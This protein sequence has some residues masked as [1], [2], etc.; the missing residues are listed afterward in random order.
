MH[1]V[2]GVLGAVSVAYFWY[3]RTRKATKIAGE[4]IEAA[5][6]V[7]LAARRFG[8]RRK[9]NVHPVD[10]I[11]DPRIAIS[12]IG[13]GFLELDGFPT[14]E[15]HEALIRGVR[16]AFRINHSSAEEM[17]VLGRWIV[18]Q[19]NGPDQSVPRLTKHLFK[20]DGHTHFEVMLGILKQIAAAGDGDRPGRAPRP[21]PRQRPAGRQQRR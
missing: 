7:R 14:A 2:L 9:A 4:L 18:T 20:L 3:L 15:K 11:D 5:N 6:D 12:A 16:E 21:H 1:I 17:I 8:F 13:S 10:A 19:C